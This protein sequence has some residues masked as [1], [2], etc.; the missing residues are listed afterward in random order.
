MSR[1]LIFSFILSIILLFVGNSAGQSED[2]YKISINENGIYKITPSL[3]EEAGVNLEGIEPRNF[4][5]TNKEREVP[6]YVSGESDGRFDAA[7]SIKFYGQMHNDGE[8]T[9][10]NIYW[11]SW[12]SVPGIRMVEEDASLLETR[13][14]KYKVPEQGFKEKVRFEIDNGRFQRYTQS[15][16]TVWYWIR[17]NT[18]GLSQIPFELM[19]VSDSLDVGSVRLLLHGSTNIRHDM[20]VF[21]NAGFRLENVSWFGTDR[22]LLEKSDIPNYIFNEGQN[23]IGVYYSSDEE[24]DSSEQV[25]LD[26]IEVEYWRNYEARADYLEFSNPQNQGN[27]LYQFEITGF[28]SPDIELYKLGGADGVSKLTDGD[29]EEE[30]GKYNLIFQDNIIQPTKY[31]ALISDQ[32]KFPV[33]IK[34]DANSDLRSVAQTDYIII[35]YEDFH[36]NAVTLSE[37]RASQGMRT[38]VVNVED[39]YD[40]FSYGIFDPR[41]IRDFIKNA[42]HNWQQPVPRYVLLLGDA[43]WWYKRDKSYVPSYTYSSK[44]GSPGREWGPVASDDYFVCVDGDDP[45]PDLF[46]GRIPASTD[47][48]ARIA[49]QKIIQYEQSSEPGEWRNSLLFLSGRQPDEPQFVFERK[50]EE[51]ID[52]Y[53]SSDYS[54]SRIYTNPNSPYYGGTSDLINAINSGRSFIRFA[55]HGGGSIWSDDDLMTLD[56]IP[57]MKNAGK[58][59]FV[60]SWTCFTS[61][62]DN[63]YTECLAEEF[64]FH[65]DGGAVAFFGSA[66]LGM[67]YADLNFEEEMYN[68]LFGKNKRI[69]G[70][71]IAE[72]KASFLTRFSGRRDY[73]DLAATYMLIGDPATR[74]VLPETSITQQLPDLAITSASISP[75]NYTVSISVKN[76]GSLD[77]ENIALNLYNSNP[78]PARA[79]EVSS[80]KIDLIGANKAVTIEFNLEIT[81]DSESV[82]VWV[83]PLNEIFELDESNNLMQAILSTNINVVTP[84]SGSNGAI[85]SSDGIFSCEIPAGAVSSEMYLSIFSEDISEFQNIQPDI[86][87]APLN[88]VHEIKLSDI[89]QVKITDDVDRNI[90]ISFR[91]DQEDSEEA[92]AIYRRLESVERWAV[93]DSFVDNEEHIVSANVS[94]P[95]LYALMINND[96]TAPQI[97]I[98]LKEQGF[99]DDDFVPTNPQISILAEDANGIESVKILLDGVLA[100]PEDMSVFGISGLTPFPVEYHPT[101]KRGKHMVR[102][103]AQD[104]NGI[105]ADSSI[106]ITVETEFRIEDIANRPNPCSRRTLFTYVLTQ[107][108]DDMIIKIYSTSGRLIRKLDAPAYAGYNELS[109]DLRDEDGRVLANG[110][111][112][113]K[114]TARSDGQKAEKIGKLAV[115]K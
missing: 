61:W 100:Q 111:Y 115:L 68:A 41:S 92:L 31:L 56:D 93:C 20:E 24:E 27:G 95:G 79:T 80:D 37:F 43:S 78:F 29:I 28:S 99:M 84:E 23:A 107:P 59:P 22:Y 106:T 38:R 14:E 71:A 54:V 72:A 47:E 69:L 6:I 67:L 73:M 30:D 96:G 82:Y 87:Y 104:L 34:K 11:L 57:L 19:S 21:L 65:K 36:D 25:L 98:T 110:A 42:Y 64:L 17:L 39:I 58:L 10:T 108:A 103:E 62:Y 81:D 77:V 16:D 13:P 70:E 89:D 109:W 114:L 50:A 112:L 51:F 8:Y 18:P 45:L 97:D 53:I 40:E 113:Y 90:V 66:G 105:T 5:M 12:N 3:L 52:R 26:W 94:Q 48:E 44:V 83:D 88:S 60:V 4:R 7:D 49:I 32:V 74:L 2:W 46:I 55:G 85:F 86:D 15:G 9:I 76:M 75:E 1:L 101:L 91:Y 33:E 35:T 63:P 102:V